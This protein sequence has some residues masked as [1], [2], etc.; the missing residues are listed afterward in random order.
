MRAPPEGAPAPTGQDELT[1]HVR[2]ASIGEVRALDITVALRDSRTIDTIENR[3]EVVSRDYGEDSV[4]LRARI[5]SR[6]LAQLRSRGA[7]MTL[8]TPDGE[9]VEGRGAPRIGRVE[10][11]R[12]DASRGSRVLIDAIAGLRPARGSARAG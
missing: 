1:E 8:H 3:A 10:G 7:E 6:Q 9:A 12:H 4:T 11:V 2:A 5:G